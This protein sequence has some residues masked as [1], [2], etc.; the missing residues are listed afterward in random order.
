MKFRLRWF[1]LS[2]EVYSLEKR[3]IFIPHPQLVKVQKYIHQNILKFVECHE[4]SFAYTPGI[5]IVD[6]ASLHTNSK[7][8]IKLDI[9]AF[10]ES[11]SEVSVYKVFRSLEFPA[12]L[13]FELARICTWNSPRNRNTIPPRFKISKKTNYT[14]YSST[15]GIELGHLPQGAPTSPSL[16]NLVC[17]E[18]DKQ[19]TAFSVKNELEY[20][21]YSDDITFSSKNINFSRKDAIEIIKMVYKILINYGFTPNIQK[22]KIISPKAKK[23]VLGLNVDREK[24][25]L[26]KKFKN[27]INQNIYF[28][29]HPDIGPVRQAK[30]KKFSSVLG[31]KNHLHGLIIYALS[32]DKEFGEKALNN[33]NK[34]VWP[35]H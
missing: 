34:I 13:S 28:C 9:T 17:R 12:L 8:L 31:F 1:L 3:R 20:S 26:D 22:T 27:K 14:V 7:W 2:Q 4:N 18:L 15:E 5:S 11:I 29:L 23:I 21:R 30:Y 19:L 32:I 16:S 6:A 24:V 35:I 25:K 33:Y 10:F